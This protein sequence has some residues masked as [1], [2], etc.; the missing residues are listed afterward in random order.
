[1]S[2]IE[3]VMKDGII[4]SCADGKER[5]CFPVLCQHIGDMEEQWLLTLTIAP[6]CPKCHHRGKGDVGEEMELEWRQ[7][8]DTQ[9]DQTTPRTDR[10]AYECR[11]RYSRDPDFPLNKWGY[12]PEGPYSRH[13]LH[14]GILDAVGPDLLHQVSKC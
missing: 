13:Y 11:L 6:I 7:D 5:L 1:M 14:G 3:K 8:G 10:D 4:L 2:S 9:G 12:H